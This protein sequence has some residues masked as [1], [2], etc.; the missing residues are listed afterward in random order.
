MIMDR[1]VVVIE[2]KNEKI[3]E[4]GRRDVIEIIP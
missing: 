1:A 3:V 4:Y 2:G